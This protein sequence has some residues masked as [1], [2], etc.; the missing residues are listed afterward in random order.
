VLDRRKFLLGAVPVRMG[1][2]R[3]SAT[4]MTAADAHVDGYPTVQA[5]RWIGETV[6]GNRGSPGIRVFHSASSVAR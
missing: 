2:A 1:A 3:E 4:V 5:V 6:A